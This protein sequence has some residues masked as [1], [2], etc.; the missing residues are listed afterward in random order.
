MSTVPTVTITVTGTI[1]AEVAAGEPVTVAFTNADG[2]VNPVVGTGV[3]TD[4]GLGTPT[5]INYSTVSVLPAAAG[6]SLQTSIGADAA[7]TAAQSPVVKFDA[8]RSRTI[9]ANVTVS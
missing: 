5:S 8:L 6:M 4:D 2:S 9:T 1:S 3:T 7:D